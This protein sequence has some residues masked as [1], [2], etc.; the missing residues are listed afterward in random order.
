MRGQE[1]LGRGLAN[2]KSAKESGSSRIFDAT[3][4][5]D[6]SSACEA[7]DCVQSCIHSSLLVRYVCIASDGS[8]VNTN[9]SSRCTATSI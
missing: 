7:R 6:K 1:Q 8:V 5:K 3:C 2:Q 9:R 4:E